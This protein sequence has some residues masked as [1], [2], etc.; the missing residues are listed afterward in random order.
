MQYLLTEE[1]YK[2]WQERDT[3]IPY[4]TLSDD[5]DKEELEFLNKIF[6]SCHFERYDKPYELGEEYVAIEIPVRIIPEMFLRMLT[7]RRRS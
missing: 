6:S 1:E 2:E 5:D 3:P 7:L 4:D